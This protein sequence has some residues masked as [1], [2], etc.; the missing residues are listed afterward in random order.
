MRLLPFFLAIASLLG[1][2]AAVPAIAQSAPPAGANAAP[3]AGTDLAAQNA[4]LRDELVTA[5]QEIVRL[6][7]EVGNRRDIEVALKAAREKNERLV[8]IANELIAAY[9]KRYQ[10]GQFLPFD[11]GRR[12][13][14]AEL[15]GFGDRAYDNRWDASPRRPATTPTSN[16]APAKPSK[17]S[18]QDAQ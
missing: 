15:Q 10:R 16:A 8:G 7:A 14:E 5:Q 17:H 2:G 13:L 1:A 4:A 6:R 3:P 18:R 9:E 11:T 12:K